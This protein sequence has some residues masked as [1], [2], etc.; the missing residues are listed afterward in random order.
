MGAGFSGLRSKVEEVGELTTTKMFK[1]KT[2]SRFMLFH[3]GTVTWHD[4]TVQQSDRV[5]CSVSYVFRG[6]GQSS[7]TTDAQLWP[8]VRERQPLDSRGSASKSSVFLLHCGHRIEDLYEQPAC[9]NSL[10][11]AKFYVGGDLWFGRK[12]RLDLKTPVED[13]FFFRFLLVAV[14]LRHFAVTASWSIHCTKWCLVCATAWLMTESI[15]GLKC[16]KNV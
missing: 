15:W 14:F 1:I 4:N 6:V 11:E 2:W 13:F 5:A 10:F 7:F 3:W 12:P 16:S 8:P 9:F